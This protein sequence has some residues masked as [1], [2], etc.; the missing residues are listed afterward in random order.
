MR[1]NIPLDYWVTYSGSVD[2]QGIDGINEVGRSG[3]LDIDIVPI[4]GVE[5]LDQLVHLSEVESSICE[6]VITSKRKE[7]LVAP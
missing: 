2:S 5:I 1:H 7:N 6:G 4:V 3:V